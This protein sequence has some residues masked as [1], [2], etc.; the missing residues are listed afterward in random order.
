MENNGGKINLLRV[1]TQQIKVNRKFSNNYSNINQA[2][3]PDYYQYYNS[4]Q[5]KILN[6]KYQPYLE[7]N[8]YSSNSI[9]S[10]Y[11]IASK[12]AINPQAMYKL[13][14]LSSNDFRSIYNQ[15]NGNINND[16][17][18]D[19]RN[20]NIQNNFK[21]NDFN[22]NYSIKP[23]GNQRKIA[24]YKGNKKSNLL[25]NTNLNKKQNYSTS[26]MNERGNFKRGTKL[27]ISK[28]EIQYPLNYK[29]FPKNK[30]KYKA[31]NNTVSNEETYEEEIS[32]N[33]SKKR[34][35]VTENENIENC[36]MFSPKK[37][38]SNKKHMRQNRS[39]LAFVNRRK[40]NL[41]ISSNNIN[42]NHLS[43]MKSTN[44]N[45]YHKKED[46]SIN[47]YSSCYNFFQKGNN[48]I[49]R[50]NEIN[51]IQKNIN[52]IEYL[53]SVSSMEENNNNINSY[54]YIP[55]EEIYEN[56]NGLNYI[57]MTEQ[58]F[59][60]NNTINR[61]DKKIN[62]DENDNND[63]Y[64]NLNSNQ[65]SMTE[66]DMDAS[67][68]INNLNNRGIKINNILSL[69][70]VIIYKKKLIEDFCN[71]IEEFIF[72]N[73]KSNF[74]NF[75]FKL[76][77][78]CKEKY[79]NNL[80]LKRLNNKNTQK[81][82]Y[83]G[84]SSSYKYYEGNSKN[85]FYPSTGMNDSNNNISKKEN[86]AFNNLSKEFTGRKTVNYYSKNVSPPMTEHNPRF[87]NN[88]RTGKSLGPRNSNQIDNYKNNYTEKNT[89]YKNEDIYNY[90]KE[91]INQYF[92]RRN[93]EERFNSNF[94]DNNIYIPKK[95]KK[96]NNY[97]IS[98]EINQKHK[99]K[100]NPYFN[101]SSSIKKRND[102]LYRENEANKS[103][104]INDDKIKEKINNNFIINKLKSNINFTSKDI[105][106]DNN[107]INYSMNKDL[108]NG[109]LNQTSG[110]IKKR[111]FNISP[112][113]NDKI[114]QNKR[115]K[116]IYKK[117]IKITQA[118]SKIFPNKNISIKNKIIKLSPNNK[119]NK[120]AIQLSNHI[121]NIKNNDN[122][123]EYYKNNENNSKNSNN[124]KK[125]NHNIPSNIKEI[126]LDLSK[127]QNI[128]ER[129]LINNKN[130]SYLNNNNI[131]DISEKN[132][133]MLNNKEN[134]EQ[135][136]QFNE[137]ENIINNENL[138][139]KNDNGNNIEIKNDIK[140]NNKKEN[141]KQDN[142]N[143]NNKNNINENNENENT[144]TNINDPNG[145]SNGN[146]VI[147]ED[148][149]ESDDNIV[150]EIIV[151]DVST[152]DK[153]LNVFIKYV[154]MSKLN[155]VSNPQKHKL[156]FFQTDSFTFQSSIKNINYNN[157][158][159][160]NNTNNKN[161]IKL[162][163]IL[164]SIIEE[165]EK[166][167]A[168]GSVNNSAIS[169]E[170]LYTN[171]NYS[172]FFIQSIK[173]ITTYLQNIFDDKKKDLYFQFFKI[174]KKIKNEAFLK[175]LIN[176]KKFQ[177]LSKLIGEE[178]ENNTS[179]DVI[180]Y[181]LNDNL[182]ADINYFGSKSNDRKDLNNLK[183]KNRNYNNKNNIKNNNNEINGDEDILKLDD[184]YSSFDNFYLHNNKKS[185]NIKKELNLS[186]DNCDINKDDEKFKSNHS[187]SYYD[188]NIC[189]KIIQLNKKNNKLKKIINDMDNILNVKLKENFFKKWVEL[190]NEDVEINDSYN[191]EIKEDSDLNENYEKNI[192]MIEACK[193]LSDVILD[194]KI[195]L[196]KYCL[197]NKNKKE[198]E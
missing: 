118:K 159:Y 152:K 30:S 46:D 34:S 45:N 169:E 113:E 127:K 101:N 25:Y 55:N 128:K 106:Y 85:S 44:S 54:N 83:K 182:N 6:F 121:L 69:N 81:N 135:N 167:K 146:N 164:S 150:K 139:N 153:R 26:L 194:F 56:E 53:K 156:F 3:Y 27:N 111:N 10:D 144:N 39:N 4:N 28:R 21:K 49:R 59:K 192:T 43:S 163:K 170:E 41:V 47:S 132:M 8:T 63:N 58:D 51:N 50:N 195:Y 18:L 115:I 133:N 13:G 186:M 73:F 171:G 7:Q 129:E 117:K 99:N 134:K 79:F 188:E 123:N 17:K 89:C 11:D 107:Y 166:S 60:K 71:C 65:Y 143:N 96:I 12:Y 57:N 23:I 20:Q 84:R 36:F 187:F 138:G 35:I 1:N 125:I 32:G 154:E 189:K 116:A 61:Q 2:I 16:F 68:N 185:L 122:N 109:L 5:E 190:K 184:K 196:M 172:Y 19:Q 88:F 67:E 149:D 92:E 15:T 165:E 136:N 37:N 77:E 105:S 93:S 75:I 97:H 119:N 98:S 179:G 198:F 155:K 9:I 48:N 103:Q 145:M 29:N 102:L 137:N 38:M 148:T 162:H 72:I 141:Y 24:S 124:L 173:Y 100:L 52:N 80:L 158:L 94:V 87:N 78:Y 151:K 86:Y 91:H 114:S 174:L 76:K 62:C 197:K 112:K 108:E 66:N 140:E 104:D 95:F 180:L 120:T 191:N 90:R 175:G 183:N 74:D 31:Y 160:G 157:Y 110:N 168:A 42:S 70:K 131:N 193:G 181:N 161:K 142:N 82:L 130:N 64:T 14:K 147:N 33:L 178:N 177:D 176:Q 126:N 40:N 22:E